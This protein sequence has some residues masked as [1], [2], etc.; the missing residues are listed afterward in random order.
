MVKA[1]EYGTG[2]GP[3]VRYIRYLAGEVPDFSCR[4]A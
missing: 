4:A 2:T 3:V 1:R